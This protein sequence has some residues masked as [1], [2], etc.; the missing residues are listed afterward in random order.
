MNTLQTSKKTASTREPFDRSQLEKSEKYAYLDIV[1][2]GFGAYRSGNVADL[3]S[4]LCGLSGTELLKAQIR[5][6]VDAVG[7]CS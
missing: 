7:A 5:A 2:E 4:P 6:A 3:S 1:G